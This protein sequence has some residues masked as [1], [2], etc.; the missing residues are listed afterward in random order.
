MP[1]TCAHFRFR[2]PGTRLSGPIRFAGAAFRDGHLLV[3]RSRCGV[4]AVF[5]GDDGEDSLAQAL[6]EAFPADVLERAQE[7]LSHELAWASALLEG[8]P[9]PGGVDLDIGGTLFQQRVWRLLCEIPS[10]Q[11]RSYTDIAIALEMPQAVRAVGGACAA[12]VLAVAIPCH[13]V[14]RSDGSITGYRWGAARKRALL[15]R[16]AQAARSR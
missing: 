4:C 13:R 10:G 15:D 14:L 6:A 2:Q 1:P 11:T 8:N 7:E 5:M 12:N 3:A 9:V 16:E